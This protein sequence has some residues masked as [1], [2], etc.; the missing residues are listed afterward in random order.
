MEVNVLEK[1]GNYLR[2]H[3]K[4]VPLHVLNSIRRVILSEVPAMA[5]ST[6]VFVEN[7]SIFYDEYVAHRLGLIPLTSDYALNK[8]KGPEECSKAEQAGSF[9]EDCFV[10]FTLNVTN[11]TDRLLTVYSGD[12]V[13]S[14]PDVKPVN[15]RIPILV[16]SPNQ[17]IKL[18]A[19][20]RFGEGREHTKWSPVSV[21]AH[22]YVA[23]ITIDHDKCKGT[24][25][26]E[27]VEACPRNVLVYGG[28]G[29]SVDPDKLLEC[30]LCRFCETICPTKAIKVS[31]RSDE[32]VFILE[33]LGS[34]QPRNILLKSLEI[35]EKKLDEFYD[36]LVNKGAFN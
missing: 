5:I 19:Y 17:S 23:D 22:K 12:L 35:L 7:N 18:E 27:C 20:A 4:G 13:S 11:E 31:W 29:V 1:S 2:M 24:D 15:D 14:D 34:L 25:C 28:E 10:R 6:V 9:S 33:S 36:Q 16:L 30:T 32:Y 3:I 26:R 8:Y 21:A